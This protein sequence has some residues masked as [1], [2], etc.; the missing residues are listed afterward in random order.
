MAGRHAKRKTRA[1]N[2][3]VRRRTA[4]GLSTTAGALV[5]A[6]VSPFA[7][8]PLAKADFEDLIMDLFDPSAIATAVDPSAFAAALDPASIT[9]TLDVGSIAVASDPSAALAAAA[10]P[11]GTFD[12]A[13]LLAGLGFTS[14][15]TPD[16][17]ELAAAFQQGFYQPVHSFLEYWMNSSVG[18]FVDAQANSL[19]AY[20]ISTPEGQQIVTQFFQQYGLDITPTAFCGLI[21]DGAPGTEADPTGGDGGLFAGDGGTGWTSTTAGVAGGNGGDAGVGI[22]NGG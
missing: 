2:R 7:I 5:A 13:A 9:A 11:A 15:G 20:F 4:A 1:R 8:A 22:G 18:Q 21:C 17:P 3:K 16:T 12:L 10:E 6:A 19:Y 14:D